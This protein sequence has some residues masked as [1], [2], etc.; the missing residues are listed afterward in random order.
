M[1]GWVRSIPTTWYWTLL[2]FIGRGATT[3][4]STHHS[5]S[6]I[7]QQ[8]KLSSHNQTLFSTPCFVS[9]SSCRSTG[10][11]A[12]FHLSFLDETFFHFAHTGWN[13]CAS[14]G[15]CNQVGRVE[16]IDPFYPSLPVRP[17]PTSTCWIAGTTRAPEAQLR[18]STQPRSQEF[19]RV[20]HRK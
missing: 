11:P 8:E 6:R 3:L 10:T 5:Q 17:C 15:S 2:R 4:T 18:N 12:A 13:M 1:R 19:C 16:T 20:Q 7:R 14:A 9:G